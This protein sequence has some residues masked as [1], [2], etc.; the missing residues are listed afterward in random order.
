V[1]A[2]DLTGAQE[3]T[4]YVDVALDKTEVAP[5]ETATLTVTRR[6]AHPKGLSVVGLVSTIDS[7]SYLWPVAVITR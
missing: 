4:R 2:V 3:H 5:G 6:K 7:N 1:S